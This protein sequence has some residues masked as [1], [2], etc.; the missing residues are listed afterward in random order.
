MRM[1][2]SEQYPAYEKKTLIIVTNN[3]VARLFLAV[4][5]EI[6]EILNVFATDSGKKQK[7]IELE[8]EKTEEDQK[9]DR[10]KLHKHILKA[11][12]KHEAAY[13]SLTLCA[14]EALKNE[15]FEA[16]PEKYKQLSN[17]VV[18][19]NLASLPIDQIVRIL[20]EKK[21]NTRP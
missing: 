7:N 19:K 8:N 3:E 18:P 6:E 12:K 14:P 2:I 9:N 15:L 5:R 4:D 1:K 13:E 16:L 21:T 10:K 11:L 20:Q 17:E